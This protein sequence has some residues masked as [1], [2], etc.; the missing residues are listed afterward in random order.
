V[1][2]TLRV[3]PALM[4]AFA[5]A[6]CASDTRRPPEIIIGVEADQPNHC[7]VKAAPIPCA[8]VGSYLQTAPKV[9]SHARIKVSCI[10]LI[11]ARCGA[12][13]VHDRLVEAGYDN[14]VDYDFVFR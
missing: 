10:P 13:F 6:G 12:A 14:L 3:V 2:P 7:W 4:L 9:S 8:D 1:S 5:S 11:S